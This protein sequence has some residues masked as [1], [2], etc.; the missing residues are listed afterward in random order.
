MAVQLA[1]GAADENPVNEGAIVFL[2]NTRKA[3]DI[4]L[5]SLRFNKNKVKY[6]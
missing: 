2:P 3:D 4:I 5:E 6:K 1:A